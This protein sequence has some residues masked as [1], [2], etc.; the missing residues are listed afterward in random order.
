MKENQMPQEEGTESLK[1]WLD[2]IDRFS[3]KR[4]QRT[5]D[6]GRGS[7]NGPGW[8]VCKNR[9]GWRDIV[10]SVSVN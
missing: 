5:R 8:M 4:T 3:K 10:N 1:S 7:V 6:S 9:K 2:G